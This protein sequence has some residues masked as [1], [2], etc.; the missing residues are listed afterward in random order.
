M[1]I[2]SYIYK[3]A[4]HFLCIFL[5]ILGKYYVLDASYQ[6]IHGFLAPY[7]N[8]RYHLQDFRHGVKCMTKEDHFNFLH[9]SLRNMIER[10]FGVLKA[11]F[12]I[13]K[14]MTL[15]HFKIQ[16]MIIIACM[17]LYN[18]IHQQAIPDDLFASYEDSHVQ[19]D[20][21]EDH[22][23]MMDES[24]ELCNMDIVRDVIVQQIYDTFH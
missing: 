1:T 17:T 7:R 10:C 6:N 14:R 5:Y 22:N 4:F 16:T 12:L 15:Y 19:I 21:D 11:Q 9:S 20:D 24:Q 23:D 18:F 13:L 2:F 8:T 3:Q